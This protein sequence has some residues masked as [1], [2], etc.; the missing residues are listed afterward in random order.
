MVELHG[1]KV[2]SSVITAQ[3]KILRTT[4]REWIGLSRRL[5]H[6]ELVLLCRRSSCTI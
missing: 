1:L 6:R 3:S 2:D 4:W 5:K